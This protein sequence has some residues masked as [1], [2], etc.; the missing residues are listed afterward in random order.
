LASI[1]F[2]HD[3]SFSASP[4]SVIAEIHWEHQ[5][6]QLDDEAQSMEKRNIRPEGALFP[7]K[8]C[9][10]AVATPLFA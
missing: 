2:V 4:V 10:W 9:H 8:S 5:R 1:R 3:A 7:M 6:S